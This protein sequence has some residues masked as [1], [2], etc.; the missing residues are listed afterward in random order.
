MTVRP[1]GPVLAD[2]TAAYLHHLRDD[3]GCIDAGQIA[4][5]VQRLVALSRRGGV[6]YVFGNGG[7]AATAAHF[8]ND[9]TRTV[10][11]GGPPRLRICCLSDNVPTI[12]AISNDHDYSEIFTRQLRN[13]LAAPDLVIG[14]SSRG[15][16]GNVLGAVRYARS[17]RVETMALVGHDGGELREVVDHAVHIP[18]HDVRRVED[19][20]LA[21]CHIVSALLGEA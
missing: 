21:V 13:Y 18:V 15:H 4:V 16:S 20:H 6:G 10:A 8:V 7:S 2:R 3:I 11:A 9:I 19:L 12:T 17:R 1:V 14:I 5:M